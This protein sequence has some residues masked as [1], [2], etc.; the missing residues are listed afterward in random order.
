MNIVAKQPISV[1]IDAANLRWLKARAAASGVRSV[2]ELLDRLIA[3]ARAKGSAAGIVTSVVGTIDV[4]RS[5]PLLLGA[6]V[7]VRGLYDTSLRRPFLVNEQ[8]TKGRVAR[9]TRTRRRG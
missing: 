8:R 4:D 3:G 5:D 1:T 6:D 2:S 9:G 7:V